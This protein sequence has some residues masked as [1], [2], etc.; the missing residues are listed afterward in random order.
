M[1]LQEYS[2]LRSDL[3]ELNRLIAMTPESA[4][5]DRMSLERRRDK[6]A[7]ELAAFPVPARWP[8]YGRLAFAGGPVTDRR[9]IDAAFLGKATEAFA[10][11]VA[12]AAAS[13]LGPIGENDSAPSRDDC[14]LLISN[15]NVGFGGLRFEEAT[16][17]H[18]LKP[19]PIPVS[20]GI[21]L[22]R[23]AILNASVK[24]DDALTDA[25]ADAHPYV[26]AALRRFLETLVSAGAVFSLSFEGDEFRFDDVEQARTSLSRLTRLSIP[27]DKSK[28]AAER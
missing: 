18:E 2:W 25:I 23:E 17:H 28:P 20:L 13:R 3:G 7:K 5:I 14:R 27:K 12:S 24:N 10:N 15:R 21:E 11:A 9:G 22:Y 4:F 1:T 26:I 6:V 16:P 8:V 19:G